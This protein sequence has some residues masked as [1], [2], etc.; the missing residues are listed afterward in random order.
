MYNG[1]FFIFQASALSGNSAAALQ[2]TL[3]SGLGA[4]LATSSLLNSSLTNDL[5]SNLT[6][7]GAGLN[8]SSLSTLQAALANANQNSSNSLLAASRLSK[9]ENDTFGGN[10]TF[11][12]TT[13]GSG[14]DLDLGSF[15]R[16]DNDIAGAAFS[17][18][19][20]SIAS[21]QAANNG[22]HNSDT[23]ILNNV[24]VQSIFFFYLKLNQI[25][26]LKTW[27]AIFFLF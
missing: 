23:I 2:A 18:N 17:T 1:I 14:R 4:N 13:L 11:G 7:L 3:A 5:A 20:G 10:N 6:Q 26:I 9:I 15:N 19:T 12:G 16:R 22:R 21:R 25:P 8:A 27:L 24:S